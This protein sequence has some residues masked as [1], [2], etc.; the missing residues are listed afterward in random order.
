MNTWLIAATIIIA[1]GLVASVIFSVKEGEIRIEPFLIALGILAAEGVTFGMTKLVAWVLTWHVGSVVKVS[2][3]MMP[4]CL[5]LGTMFL[6]IS[7][8][9]SG[10]GSGWFS[11]TIM[12]LAL[13]V[14]SGITCMVFAWVKITGLQIAILT[15]VGLVMIPLIRFEIYCMVKD[16]DTDSGSHNGTGSG[17]YA[18]SHGERGEIVEYYS[19]KREYRRM[20]KNPRA[21]SDDPDNWLWGW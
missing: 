5:I 19:S 11:A 21:K 20:Q 4:A 18:V 10:S 6:I 3:L 14:A 1:L 12:M 17:S 16:N 9:C 2:F 13:L 7:F 8:V 15:I